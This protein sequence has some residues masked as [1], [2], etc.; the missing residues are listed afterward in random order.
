MLNINTTAKVNPKQQRI[1]DTNRKFIYS[2]FYYYI[3][4]MQIVYRIQFNSYSLTQFVFHNKLK[5]IGITNF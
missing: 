1:R 2:A 3:S 5:I 4:H